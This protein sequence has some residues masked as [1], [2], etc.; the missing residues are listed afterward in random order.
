MEVMILIVFVILHYQVFEMTKK[1]IESILSLE[2]NEVVGIVIVDNCSTNGSGQLLKQLYEHDNRIT[3]LI[4]DKNAGFASGNNI[5]YNFALYKYKPKAV[6]V[7]NND[8]VIEQKDFIFV[9]NKVLIDEKYD[10]IAPNIINLRGKRQNPYS[11]FGIGYFK[12]LRNIFITA[13]SFFLYHFEIYANY[14]K[15]RRILSEFVINSKEILPLMNIVCHGACVIYANNWL[16]KVP[17]AFVPG[18]FMYVEEE[19]LFEYQRKNGFSNI[20][21]PRLCVKHFEDVATDATS[22]N[23]RHKQIFSAKHSFYSYILLLKLKLGWY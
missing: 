18:T 8:V 19:I 21:Y 14:K 1:C 4:N 20:Y 7:M 22:K 3:V 16:L 15:R 23:W 17:F 12:L 13:I 5:G 6:V 2:Q 11:N 10:I 9:L